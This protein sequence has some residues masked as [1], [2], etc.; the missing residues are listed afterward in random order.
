VTKLV[1]LPEL[2]AVAEGLGTTPMLLTADADGRPRVAATTLTFGID[3]IAE[4][5]SAKAGRKSF[6]NAERRPLVS[7]LWPAPPGTRFALIADGEVLAAVPEPDPEG[8]GGDVVI[9]LSR[10]MLHVVS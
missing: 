2:L 6:A 4:R 3:G 7:L 9:D 1:E 5:V 8:R 10:A